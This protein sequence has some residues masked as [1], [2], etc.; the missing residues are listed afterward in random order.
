MAV[1]VTVSGSAP[2]GNRRAVWGTYTSAAGDNSVT[3]THGL[4]QVDSFFVAQE[5]ALQPQT[6]KIVHAATSGSTA[7]NTVLTYDDTQGLS[8]R[9]RVVGL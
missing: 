2:A 1:T 6:P 7:A 3:I 9:W 4:S 5:G 8:G